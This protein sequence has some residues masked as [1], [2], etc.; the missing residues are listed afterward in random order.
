MMSLWNKL[1]ISTILKVAKCGDGYHFRIPKKIVDSFELK[2][3][4]EIHVDLKTL[5]KRGGPSD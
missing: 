1:G 2:P 3:G 4:D 5:R